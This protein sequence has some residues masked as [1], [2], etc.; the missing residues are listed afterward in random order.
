MYILTQ[1]NTRVTASMYV[2]PFRR[3]EDEKKGTREDQPP[4]T[5]ARYPE[6]ERYTTR[7]TARARAA[8]P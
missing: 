6:S 3:R 2:L 5:R 4:V 1:I 8:D 7:E